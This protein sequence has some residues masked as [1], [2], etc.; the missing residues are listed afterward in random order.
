MAG[1]AG[2]SEPGAGGAVA[3]GGAGDG[4]YGNPDSRRNTFYF[5]RKGTPFNLTLIQH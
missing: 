1:V 3:G 5:L 4:G 2:D